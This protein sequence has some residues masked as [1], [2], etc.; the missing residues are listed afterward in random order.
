[1]IF[2]LFMAQCQAHNDFINVLDAIIGFLKKK[3]MMALFVFH[4][5]SKKHTNTPCKNL[6]DE[7][8]KKSI[9]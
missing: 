2:L 5:R 9:Q 1:M 6:I 7:K 8:H 4:K 3:K